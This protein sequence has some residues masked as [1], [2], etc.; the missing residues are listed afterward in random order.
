MTVEAV[1]LADSSFRRKRS[2]NGGV[3]WSDEWEQDPRALG[4]VDA[5]MLRLNPEAGEED[6][7]VADVTVGTGL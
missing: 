5:V 1:G 4:P 7:P 6:A 2:R 3:D